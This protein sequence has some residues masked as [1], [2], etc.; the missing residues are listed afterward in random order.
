MTYATGDRVYVAWQTDPD[1]WLVTGRIGDHVT[2]TRE[3]DG[4]QS[5]FAPG[6]LHPAPKEQT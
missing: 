6:D 4:V 1:P 2:V 5:V 3:C